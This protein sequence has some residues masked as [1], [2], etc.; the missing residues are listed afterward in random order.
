MS[1]LGDCG[2]EFE[3]PRLTTVGQADGCAGNNGN[4]LARGNPVS[5]HDS[6]APRVDPEL[7]SA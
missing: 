7:R 4:A 3:L 5:G 2:T 6:L 1:L